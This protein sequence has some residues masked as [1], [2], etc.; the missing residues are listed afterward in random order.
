[1]IN[2]TVGPVQSNEEVLKVGSEQIPYFRTQEFSNIIFENERI[3]KKYAGASEDSKVV[4]ITGSGTASMEASVINTLTKDDKALVIN[5]GSFGKRFVDLCKIH[6]IPYTEISIKPGNSLKKEE[7]YKYD[8]MG[9]TAL[10]INVHETSTGVL[11][12]MNIV[13]DFCKKNNIFMIND[14][15]S[16]FIADEYNM[17]ELGADVMITGSQKALACPPGISIII[18]SKRAIDRINNNNPKVLYLNLKNALKDA[19]RGQTP[20]TPAVGILLQINARLKKIEENGGI[21]AEREKIKNIANDFRK[22]INQEK[23]PFE[24]VSESMSNAVTSI[25]PLNVSAYDIFLTLKDEYD[26]WVCPN[27]GDLKEKIFRVGHIGNL[28]YEDNNQLINALNDMK[29]RGIL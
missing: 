1:M 6:E 16:S 25:H 14:C 24:F 23:F 4:F 21:E 15:I 26:I 7:L 3:I 18:L 8:G 27:G 29:K 19:E 20:F 13:S 22:R 5:G 17:K 28:T 12:D 10:L 9:Y 2:F 11:Y